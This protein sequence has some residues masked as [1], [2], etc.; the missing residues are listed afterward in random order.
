MRREIEE[1]VDVASSYHESIIGL[2]N[3]DET[4]VGRVHL[5]VV[6][7][8]NLEEPRVTSRES[9]LHDFGFATPQ[10]LIGQ[11]DEFESWSQI[12]LRHVARDQLV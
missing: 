9:S 6:H 8:F 12:C 11:L 5:G 4:A 10:E 7:V 1:E 3:D 2:I